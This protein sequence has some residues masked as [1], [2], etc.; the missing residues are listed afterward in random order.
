MTYKEQLKTPEW[1]EKRLS[2]LKRDNFQCQY[3][4]RNAKEKLLHVHHLVYFQN[5]MAWEY[6]NVYLTTYCE[7]CH[8]DWH[9]TKEEI[10]Y[11]LAVDLKFLNLYCLLIKQIREIGHENFHELYGILSNINSITD[12]Y[13]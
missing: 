12:Y 10:D 3:C 13:G 9:I 6:D 2:I 5:V 7:K 8:S 1:K 11:Y 4:N